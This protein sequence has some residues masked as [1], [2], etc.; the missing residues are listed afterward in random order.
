[1]A[2]N[3]H[4]NLDQIPVTFLDGTSAVARSEGNNAAWHC[5]C[6]ATL[7]LI[8]RCYFQFGH[9]PYTT[10]PDTGCRKVYL[11][12]GNDDKQAIEVCEVPAF[13]SPLP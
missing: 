2:G 10:C 4:L 1:M 8:G 9:T 6:G 7:P 5:Q 13:G 3:V 11:V 12:R